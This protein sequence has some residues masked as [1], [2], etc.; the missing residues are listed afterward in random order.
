METQSQCCVVCAT[1]VPTY[2]MGWLNYQ[3]PVELIPCYYLQRGN[4]KM[5]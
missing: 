2:G 4:I 5:R 1:I 3:V